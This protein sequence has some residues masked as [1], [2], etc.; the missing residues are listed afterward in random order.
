MDDMR[1]DLVSTGDDRPAICRDEKCFIYRGNC[2]N[3]RFKSLHNEGDSPLLSSGLRK[4]RVN[5]ECRREIAD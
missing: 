5:C 2:W 1:A 4:E 3:L